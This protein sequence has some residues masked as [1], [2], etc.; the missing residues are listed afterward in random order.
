MR[1]FGSV[2]GSYVGLAFFAAV[3]GLVG[4]AATRA[5]RRADDPQG[6]RGGAAAPIAIFSLYV[7]LLALVYATTLNGFYT[8]EIQQGALRLG[9]LPPWPATTIPLHSVV[10]AS[11]APAFKNRWRLRVETA[12]GEIYE[13][14]T[15]DRDVVTAAAEWLAVSRKP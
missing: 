7:G 9:Y 6:R 15:S 3:F 14:A 4:F 10:G 8:A 1:Q 5:W 2:S 13:S 11:R 12:S